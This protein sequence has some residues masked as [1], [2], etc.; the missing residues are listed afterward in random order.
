MSMTCS[1]QRSIMA[2]TQSCVARS[3]FWIFLLYLDDP[4]I[5]EKK[6]PGYATL[7]PTGAESLHFVLAKIEFLWRVLIK[8]MDPL[9]SPSYPPMRPQRGGLSNT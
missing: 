6:W 3:L 9:W 7:G 2:P 4:N 8:F 5:T 1:L